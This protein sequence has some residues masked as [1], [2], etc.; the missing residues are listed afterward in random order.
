MT[1]FRIAERVFADAWIMHAAAVERLEAS[2]IRDA[3][4]KAWCATKRATDALIM[5]RTGQEPR[6]SGQT[7]RGVRALGRN[8]DEIRGLAV[9]YGN[10]ESVLHGSC[11]YDGD[12]EPEDELARDIR[13][14]ADY[15]LDAERL[16]SS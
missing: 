12:C 1:Q 6:T 8:D 15:I 5:E 16:A 2:D 11:F 14:T 9:R 4:E 7:R 3:S 13:E 10:R